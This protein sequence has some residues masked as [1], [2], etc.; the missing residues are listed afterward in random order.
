MNAPIIGA[1]LRPFRVPFLQWRIYPFW[2]GDA[3]PAIG[4]TDA[5]CI[6]ESMDYLDNGDRV[7]VGRAWWFA[8]YQIRDPLEEL[9]SDGETVFQFAGDFESDEPETGIST[10]SLD[11]FTRGYIEALLFTERSP[12]Y[13][14]AEWFGDECQAALREG[15]SDGTLPGDVDET[16]FHPVALRKIVEDCRRFQNDCADLLRRAYSYHY[17]KA[18]RSLGWDRVKHNGYFNPPT[19]HESRIIDYAD[20]QELCECEGIEPG[21]PY[22]EIQA[23]RD[24]WF[25]R[26][27]HGVGFWDR[28]LGEIGDLL[29]ERCGYGTQFPPADPFFGDHVKY[30]NAHFI[31]ID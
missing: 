7:I 9:A 25:T 22:T 28:G 31:H 1:F 30:G 2:R 20:W 16:N 10:D 12:A 19:G 21:E 27:G 23:G 5:P 6:A 14:A 24:F 11:D 18:A 26:N 29:S 15:Q 8:D 17:E 4:L 13:N 3:N